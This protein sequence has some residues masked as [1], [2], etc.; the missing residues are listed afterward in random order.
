LASKVALKEPVIGST[1][2]NILISNNATDD[3]LQFGIAG[4]SG[5]Y[6]DERNESDVPDA[7]PTAN[8]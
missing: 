4:G 5:D 3:E 1:E 2:S 7:I 8:R 6:E